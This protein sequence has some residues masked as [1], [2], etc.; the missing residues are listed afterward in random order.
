MRQCA[1][2]YFQL[3]WRYSMG[4]KKDSKELK[5]RIVLDAI[6]GQKR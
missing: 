4:R 1:K 5:A 6:K 3:K 2:V